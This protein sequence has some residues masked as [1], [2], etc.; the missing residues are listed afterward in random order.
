PRL[1]C[2]EDDVIA[3]GVGEGVDAARGVGGNSV[4][5]DADA[6]EVIAEAGL[7]VCPGR[8][9]ERLARRRDDVVDDRRG[10]AV[11]GVRG[12]RR[13]ALNPPRPRC[14]ASRAPSSLLL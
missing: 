6:G 9:A 1:P 7:E 5:V 10:F 13:A 14:S 2:A 11:A 4:A 12:S 8:G 3:D